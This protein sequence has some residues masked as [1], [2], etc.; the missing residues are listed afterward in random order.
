M[1]TISRRKTAPGTPPYVLLL[2]NLVLQSK[3][4]CL[5]EGRG[6]TLGHADRKVGTAL[7]P[8]RNLTSASMETVL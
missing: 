1:L 3:Q 8:G 4:P 6:A 5:M 2:D 7:S